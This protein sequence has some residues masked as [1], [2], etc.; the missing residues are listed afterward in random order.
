[1]RNGGCLA[2]GDRQN[3]QPESMVTD[4]PEMNFDVLSRNAQS[5]RGGEDVRNKR[6]PAYR[7]HRF[8]HLPS[9]VSSCHLVIGVVGF[10]Q[11]RFANFANVN[12][13]RNVQEF[14]RAS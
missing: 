2:A 14:Q 9:F 6:R 13:P 11:L 5:A 1:M 4:L 12:Y 3:T 7:A 10:N 8:Q